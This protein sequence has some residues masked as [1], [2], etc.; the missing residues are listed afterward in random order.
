MYSTLVLQA[1]RLASADLEDLVIQLAVIDKI[2]SRPMYLGCLV[3]S[4]VI[5]GD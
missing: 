2:N 3:S 4:E 1:A 5:G